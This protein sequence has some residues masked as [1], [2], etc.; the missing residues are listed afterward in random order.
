MQ[1]IYHS[2]AFIDHT[3]LTVLNKINIINY[4][5]MSHYLLEQKQNY[6]VSYHRIWFNGFHVLL[7]YLLYIPESSTLSEG[8]VG[9]LC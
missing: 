1:A 9:V 6:C 4:Y 5:E 2:S 7:V 3:Y 8:V